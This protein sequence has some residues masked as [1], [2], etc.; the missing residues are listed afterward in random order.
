MK[1]YVILG[2]LYNVYLWYY[3]EFLADA[4]YIFKEKV[5]FSDN[6]Q[7]NSCYGNIKYIF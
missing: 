7:L 5:K 1:N 4:L 6:Q 3:K 2:S